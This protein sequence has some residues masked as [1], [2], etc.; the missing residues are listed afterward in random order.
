MEDDNNS[1]FI[2]CVQD[3]LNCMIEDKILSVLAHYCISH[4][5]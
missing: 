3:A 2:G 1:G 4:P 5:Q